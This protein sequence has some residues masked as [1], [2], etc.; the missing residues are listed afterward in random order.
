MPY[1]H[2]RQKNPPYG[3]RGEVM[4]TE[5]RDPVILSYP[6]PLINWWFDNISK[7]PL[8]EY[9]NY[10]LEDDS[11]QGMCGVTQHMAPPPPQ[12]TDG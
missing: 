2:L 6:I 12:R 5:P 4:G 8:K 10:H 11:L 1:N 9:L 7:K 3:K